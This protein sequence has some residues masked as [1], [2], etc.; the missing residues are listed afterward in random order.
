MFNPIKEILD[1]LRPAPAEI[2]AACE[3]TPTTMPHIQEILNFPDNPKYAPRMGDYYVEYKGG[4]I[5]L[6][7]RHFRRLYVFD[8]PVH[9][10]ELTLV[11]S[12]KSLRF[13]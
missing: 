2:G 5:I 1:L 7:A 6:P 3:I 9:E 11:R 4:E 10:G 12:R 8:G 13:K